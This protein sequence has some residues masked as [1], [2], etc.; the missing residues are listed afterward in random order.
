MA[1]RIPETNQSVILFRLRNGFCHNCGTRIYKVDE[2][3][4]PIK[5]IQLTLEGVV[6]EGRCL[7]CYP[8]TISAAAAPPVAAAAF[9]TLPSLCSSTTAAS[10]SLSVPQSQ[11][12]SDAQESM[13]SSAVVDN[14]VRQQS[15]KSSPA[16]VPMS[17]EGEFHPETAGKNPRRHFNAK[18]LP[19]ESHSDEQNQSE[20]KMAF[21]HDIGSKQWPSKKLRLKHEPLNS[22]EED[23]KMPAKLDDVKERES[24]VGDN[25]DNW[26]LGSS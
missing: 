15:K 7:F 22:S 24:K 20:D 17:L 1:R 16:T 9:T 14:A 23:S 21:R 10:L 12:R 6:K 18:Q 11:P 2:N 26:D 5:M 13:G 4:F 3:T 25:D 8:L 19:T